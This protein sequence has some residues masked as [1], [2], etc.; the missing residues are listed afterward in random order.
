MSYDTE[1]KKNNKTEILISLLFLPLY[2]VNIVYGVSYLG[3]SC[4]EPVGKIVFDL[5]VWLIV[6]GSCGCLKVMCIFLKM[7]DTLRVLAL[8]DLAWLVIGNLLFWNGSQNCSGE[9]YNLGLANMIIG[10]ISLFI[11]VVMMI[12]LC[13]WVKKQNNHSGIGMV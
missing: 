10:Y 12:W 13:I 7:E 4:T 6:V 9:L 1:Q 5:P 11:A 8:N 2:I 3:A